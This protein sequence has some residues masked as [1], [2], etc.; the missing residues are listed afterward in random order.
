MTWP[1]TATI[2]RPPVGP[3]TPYSRIVRPV[4]SSAAAEKLEKLRLLVPFERPS[5][6]PATCSHRP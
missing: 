6:A 4:K 1:S 3:T 5:V 2:A